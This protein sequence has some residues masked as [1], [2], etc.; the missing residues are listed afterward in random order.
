[1]DEINSSKITKQ[2]GKIR[3]EKMLI[4]N[5]RVIILFSPT[6]QTRVKFI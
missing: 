4:M 5:V 6:L 3:F 1:M 2:E